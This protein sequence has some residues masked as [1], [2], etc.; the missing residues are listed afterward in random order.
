[1][2]SFTLLPMAAFLNVSALCLFIRGVCN[3]LTSFEAKKCYVAEFQYW[4]IWFVQWIFDKIDR[5]K[6]M[7]QYKSRT[8]L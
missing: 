8:F 7:V 4:I 5:F 2:V 3:K 1:M 6:K